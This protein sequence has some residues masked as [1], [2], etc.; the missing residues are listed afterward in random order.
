MPAKSG[1]RYGEEQVLSWDLARHIALP[2][3][4]TRRVNE[5]TGDTSTLQEEMGGV[6]A[7]QPGQDR[8]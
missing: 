1:C 7:P 2:P 8:E 6:G 5:E 3:S 4:E